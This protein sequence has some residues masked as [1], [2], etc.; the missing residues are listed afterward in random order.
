MRF[1]SSSARTDC[2]P[3][4]ESTI[5]KV[6]DKG[7]SSLASIVS[8]ALVVDLLSSD[9]DDDIE[10]INV[11]DSDKST[12]VDDDDEVLFEAGFPAEEEEEEEEEKLKRSCSF[13]ESLGIVPSQGRACQ[14]SSPAAMAAITAGDDFK[15]FPSLAPAVV[16]VVVVDR[17]D[18]VLSL[19]KGVAM[20]AEADLANL[21]TAS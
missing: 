8:S 15:F 16:V 9:E 5:E 17:V 7:D 3:G 21:T 13:D 14:G 18:A 12:E 4:D 10:G 2:R 6:A 1:F 11:I 19:V 20:V